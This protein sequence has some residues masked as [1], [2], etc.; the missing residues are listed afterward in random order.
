VSSRTPA[1]RCEAR[2][3]GPGA[4]GAMMAIFD[5]GPHRPFVVWRHA[6]DRMRQGVREMLACNAYAVAEFDP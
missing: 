4:W 1:A 2:P 6:D 3:C 5:M